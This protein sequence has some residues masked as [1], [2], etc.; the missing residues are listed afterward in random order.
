MDI[1]T[2][3]DMLSEA[4]ASGYKKAVE[5]TGALPAYISLNKAYKKYKRRRVDLWIRNKFITPRPVS[6]KRNGTLELSRER[7]ELLASLSY[8]D[9]EYR[10]IP[11]EKFEEE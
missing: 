4:Y 2:L 10:K 9:L 6:G 3:R 5:D 11:P 8:L 1:Y 7:L